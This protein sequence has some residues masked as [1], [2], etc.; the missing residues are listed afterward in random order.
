MK[1]VVTSLFGDGFEESLRGEFGSV[2]FVFAASERDQAREIRDADVFMGTPSREVF[3]AADHLRWMHCPGTGIDKLS[4]IPEIVDSDVVLTNARGPHTAPMADHVM[5]LCLA[6]AH[7]TNEMLLDQKARVW[8]TRKYDRAQVEM[9]GATMGI[10]ALGGIGQAVARRA[11]GFGMEVYAV[12]KKPFPPPPGVRDVWS[13]DRLD[14]LLRMSDWFVVTAPYT[15]DSKGMIGARELGLMKPS[16]HLIIISRGGIVDEDALYDTLEN[17][18][19]AGAGID[20]FEVEPLP[21]DS[22][23]WGLENVIISPHASALTVEM[24]E[25]RREIFK[26]NLRRFLANEPFIYVCD[27]TAGF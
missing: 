23:W 12:D 13:L 19:I 1:V 27:K 7:K 26:E 14:D 6:F 3:R 17:G 24:W 21:E 25:G 15:Q 18:R 4:D 10:L 22:G 8:D 11:N 9:E 20:A 2:D 16:S 5:A